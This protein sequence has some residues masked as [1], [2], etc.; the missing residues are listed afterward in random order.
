MITIAALILAAQAVLFPTPV[1]LTRQITDPFSAS[2]VVVE[3]YCYGNRVV[4][5]RGARTTI[6]DYERGELTEIDRGAGTY[7]ITSF[8]DV[9]KAGAGEHSAAARA[10]ATK[11]RWN[12]RPKAAR[13]SKLGRNAEV[14]ELETEALLE[15]QTI[16]VSID[17]SVQISPAAAEVLLGVAYPSAKRADAEAVMSVARRPAAGRMQ[18]AANGA[19][20]EPVGLPV[21]RITRIEVGGERI[22]HRD[23]IVRIGSELPDPQ[24]L[25]LPPDATRIESRLTTRTRVLE[26]LDRLVPP[27]AAK[28]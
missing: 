14:Y 6:A 9:A 2:P 8:E 7:S 22:E 16:E 25:A 10:S 20:A 28:P 1:H 27:A 17:S 21:E 4:T 23:T 15:K 12:V 5:V 18:A 19:G 13:P 24:L 11:K 3:Q 26:E